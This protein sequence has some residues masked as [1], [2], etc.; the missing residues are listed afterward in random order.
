MRASPPVCVR[1][2]QMQM[3]V[4]MRML[5]GAMGDECFIADTGTADQDE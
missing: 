2:V 4:E 5:R 3:A 1:V